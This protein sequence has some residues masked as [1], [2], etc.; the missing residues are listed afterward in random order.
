MVA[1]SLSIGLITWVLIMVLFVKVVVSWWVLPVLAHQKLKRNGFRGPPPTFPLGNIAEMKRI[2]KASAAINGDSHSFPSSKVSHDIHSTVFPHFAQ[3]QASYGKKFVY[4][5]GTEP[6]L[7]IADPHFMKQ[8]SVAVMAKGWGK[9]AVFRNDRRP[10]FGD[11]LVMTEGDVWVRHRHIL[12]PAFNPANLKAMT[13]FM[14][15]STTKMLNEWSSLVNS[16]SGEIDVEREI[17]ATAGDIIAKASFGIC[18]GGGRDAF[19]YLRAL[20]FTLFQN[21]TYVGVPFSSLFFCPG[22]TLAAKRLGAAIDRLFLSLVSERKLSQN[23]SSDLLSRLIEGQKSTGDVG[24]MGLTTREL[25]DE[26]KTFFF[27]GHETTA[28][29]TSWT[30]LLLATRPEWQDILREEIKEVIGDKEIDFN[31]LSGLKKMGCVFSEVLRL[32][33]SAPNIQRQA[34][35]DIEVG[36]MTI[37]KGTNI[38][39]DIVAMHRDP[40][41]WGDDANEFKPERFVEDSIRGGCNHKMGYLPFGFGGRMCIGKSLSSMEYKIVLT[42]ILSRFSLSLSPNYSH[43][44]ATLLSLRPAH[45]LPL[46]VTP[47]HP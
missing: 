41:L 25:V 4:W 24:K 46:I 17:T 45:G 9:P 1:I 13:K 36:S 8:I 33:P 29:A 19:D 27:G 23:S 16:A 43:S 39:I 11:G 28:L 31:M 15:E 35:G 37:P 12:T 40:D 6:F 20:Q 47:L 38:W 7:Y 26:C 21:S 10:M 30:L 14:V 3:W 18:N 44:P 5:L 22:R 34:K 2:R 42:L 32:Y